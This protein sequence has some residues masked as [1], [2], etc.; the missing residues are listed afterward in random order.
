MA[1]DKD[2]QDYPVFDNDVVEAF[3]AIV[4]AYYQ[5]L[6][7]I[8]STNKNF[9]ARGQNQQQRGYQ[10]IDVLA[11]KEKETVIVSVTNELNDKTSDLRKLEKFF[12]RALQYLKKTPEYQWLATEE[13]LKN[14]V[15]YISGPKKGGKRIEEIEK[16]LRKKKIELMD[17]EKIIEQLKK[18]F[19]DKDE[20]GYKITNNK[21]VRVMQV[22]NV[23]RKREEHEGTRNKQK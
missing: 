1:M 4:E 17:A 22:L 16:R 15:V 8:T 12:Q 13:R 18:Y 10:D 14:Q 21:I 23:L 7:Y 3:E 5:S 9:W 19:E 6:G 20:K 11:I 2:I